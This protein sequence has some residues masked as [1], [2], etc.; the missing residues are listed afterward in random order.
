LAADVGADVGAEW[1][2]DFRTPGADGPSFGHIQ[3]QLAPA[4]TLPITVRATPNRQRPFGLRT[5]WVHLRLTAQAVDRPG[6]PQVVQ[7]RVACTP[8]LGP[9]HLLVA[10]A[11]LTVLAAGLV[12][13][14][15]ALSQVLG[16]RMAAVPAGAPPAALP[17][18]AIIV[19]MAAPVPT[20][21]AE[22]TPASQGTGTT[23]G[24]LRITSV[25]Q[26]GAF[27]PAAPV[28][29][30]GQVS[31]PGAPAAAGQPAAVA[32]S[33]PAQ[34]LTYAQMFQE[35]AL[36]YDLDWRLLA[37]QAYMESDFDSLAVGPQ[38]ALGLMQILP[39]TWNEW[40]PAAGVAD[41]FDAYQ[42]VTAAAAYLDYLRSELGKMGYP[43]Q[44]W[45]LVAYNWGPDKLMDF[46]RG[47]GTWD[48][49]DDG[50][51]TYASEALRIAETI[52]SN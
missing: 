31:A 23:A 13:L 15:V 2:L 16:S 14:G 26:A 41:P 10:G 28:V 27:D 25:G 20:R 22:L 40:A 24:P 39:A 6:A 12:F 44:E 21:P 32:A 37:A 7:G 48:T 43:Q 34:E 1:T 47:G 29:L 52:P 8:F 11:V 4:E 3:V 35:I 51:R 42:N 36:R 49:L 19:N 30:P 17:S 9:L 50:V 46:L 38:G 45:M 5:Q 33:P 18:V